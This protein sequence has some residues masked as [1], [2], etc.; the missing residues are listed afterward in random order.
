LLSRSDANRNALAH[1]SFGD[2]AADAFGAA[3]DDGGFVLEIHLGKRLR[4][5]MC[6]KA[7][8]FRPVFMISTARSFEAQPRRNEQNSRESSLGKAKP[9]RT[10]G[11][12]AALRSGKVCGSR[13]MRTRRPRSQHSEVVRF[14]TRVKPSILYE[15]EVVIE[16]A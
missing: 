15:N 16:L 8:P 13:L 14:A 11:G 6:G 10:S 7:L 3:G 5:L 4:R 1:Q 9:Y 2:R 12:R